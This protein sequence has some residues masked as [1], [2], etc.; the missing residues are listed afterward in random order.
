[1]QVRVA[2][3]LSRIAAQQQHS[4]DGW[5]ERVDAWDKKRRELEKK[6]AGVRHVLI[7][8]W[9]SV[10]LGTPLSAAQKRQRGPI[11]LCVTRRGP[12]PQICLSMVEGPGLVPNIPI[13]RCLGLACKL[14]SS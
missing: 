3:S 5:E 8:S 2:A 6:H 11:G 7:S 4:S 14:W 10:R 13:C 12:G 9:R 1:M